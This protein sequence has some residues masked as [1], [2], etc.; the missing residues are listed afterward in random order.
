MRLNSRRRHQ[1]VAGHHDHVV[2]H[3]QQRARAE[4]EVE[5]E[6]HVDEDG[7]HRV[8]QRHHALVAQLLADLRARRSPRG[9]PRSPASSRPW[10]QRLRS[11]GPPC[12]PPPPGSR[13]RRPAPR[14]ASRTSFTP[15][16]AALHRL[17]ELPRSSSFSLG[18]EVD[19][20]V[21]QVRRGRA[22]SSPS[23]CDR[24]LGLLRALLGQ[25]GHAAHAEQERVLVRRA[26]ALHRD[27]VQPALLGALRG[28]RSALIGVVELHLD[29]RAAGEV[30]AEVEPEDRDA[31][32]DRQ[33]D[34]VRDEQRR[35]A[36][37]DEVDVRLVLE[38]LHGAL[39]A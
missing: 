18:A 31:H 27:V 10:L 25:L 14:P 22:S 7:E 20:A 8:E 24:R 37:A 28:P 36:L 32:Q 6:R 26:D 12:R 17:L 16:P 35:L 9:A 5:P 3:R 29:Q 2:E 34:T 33:V 15:V 38:N 23:A 39:R 13:S 21:V 30:D 4:L 1:V 11:P 19:D